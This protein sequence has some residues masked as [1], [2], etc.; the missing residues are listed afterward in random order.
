MTMDGPPGF[1][2]AMIVAGMAEYDDARRVFDRRADKHPAAILRCGSVDDVRAAL[3]F[4][5]AKGLPIAV[6]SGGHG[7]AG[8]STID[9]GLL[10]DLAAMNRVTLDPAR[11]TV[12]VEPGARTGRVLRATVPAGFAPVTCAGNDIGV[13]GAALFAG[14]GYLSPHHGNMCDNVLS[15]D[16]LRADG[17]LIRVSRDEH[18]DLF[19]AMRGAG[20]NFG[21]VVA[22]EMAVHA[23]PPTIRACSI[24]YDARDAARV[25]RLY[26][27]HDWASPL[28][29]LLGSLYPDAAEGRPRL[30]YLFALTG[31]EEQAR[32]DLD[33]LAGIVPPLASSVEAMD[34]I[35]LHDCLTFAP[36]IRFH[37]AQRELHA[38]DDASIALML[39]ELDRLAADPGRPAPVD[40][41]PAGMILFYPTDAAMERPADPPNAYSLRGGY[42]LEAIALWRN[43]ALDAH[44]ADWA[45]AVIDRF[46]RAGLATRASVL[47][48]SF[49]D[50]ALTRNCFAEDYARLAA[51]KRIHDPDGLFGST[52][53]LRPV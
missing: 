35:G 28:P 53:I 3:S 43:A 39:D 1:E 48:N 15:F 51:L 38:L 46:V 24:E 30:S 44:H 4:A 12:R 23:V 47:A 42:D 29:W 9:G 50:E 49:V 2:G 37:I 31:S 41:E 11:R 10:I 22:A 6:R 19:W 13:V 21:I 45:E 8:R 17:K 20:D 34:W 5:Q 32:R 26:R 52:A 18:P 7:F 40:G 27:D 33:A 25:M 14:Q 16:L 36:D